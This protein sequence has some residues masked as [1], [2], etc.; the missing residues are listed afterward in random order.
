MNTYK[1]IVAPFAHEKRK[2][3]EKAI[4]KLNAKGSVVS[5]PAV[6]RLTGIPAPTLYRHQHE[7]AFALTKRL[8]TT[9]APT[10]ADYLYLIAHGYELAV[11]VSN[12]RY[13]SAELHMS[14]RGTPLHRAGFSAGGLTKAILTERMKHTLPTTSLGRALSACV[15]SAKQ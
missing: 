11:T 5:V 14:K 4:A 7:F 3:I 2:Q 15:A 8:N 10:N 9:D 13:K 12:S 1:K 6:A